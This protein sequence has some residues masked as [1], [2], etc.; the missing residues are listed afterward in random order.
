[1]TRPSTP[2]PGLAAEARAGLLVTAG[3]LLVGAPLGLLWALLAPELVVRTSGELPGSAETGR[4]LVQADGTFVLLAAAAGLLCAAVASALGRRHVLGTA[5]GLV[6]G[7]AL[8]AEV[9]RRTG[10]L[11]G[12]EEARALL[13]AATDGAASA[14]VELPVRLR[15]TSALA[16]WPL[17]AL[18]LHTVVLGTR[19]LRDRA[20]P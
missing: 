14:A 12:R 3:C 16:V 4:V 17:A 20:T 1:V 6:V 11:V 18:V 13:A 15:A 7:G 8:A 10:T 9:A 2:A 19:A 5:L